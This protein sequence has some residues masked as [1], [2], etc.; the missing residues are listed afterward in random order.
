MVDARRTGRARHK[1]LAMRAL[2][3][4]ARADSLD[5]GAGLMLS[6]WHLEYIHAA[7]RF[8]YLTPLFVG[9]ARWRMDVQLVPELLGIFS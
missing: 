7:C 9:G 1:G 6:K 2:L 5:A 4:T 8:L 3:R